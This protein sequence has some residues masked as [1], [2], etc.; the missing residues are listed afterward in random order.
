MYHSVF[1]GFL[2]NQFFEASLD[3]MALTTMHLYTVGSAMLA[4]TTQ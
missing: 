2:G 3:I 4:A 1:E